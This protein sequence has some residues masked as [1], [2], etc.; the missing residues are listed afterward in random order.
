MIFNRLN[1]IEILIEVIMANGSLWFVFLLSYYLSS[2]I[3]KKVNRKRM[4]SLGTEYQN[5][6][7]EEKKNDYKPKSLRCSLLSIEQ[8][9][10]CNEFISVNIHMAANK[11]T[12]KSNDPFYIGKIDTKYR[13]NVINCLW[14][15]KRKKKIKKMIKN[16]NKNS[17]RCLFMDF[18][19]TVISS[20]CS[21]IRTFKRMF[22]NLL[23]GAFDL[24]CE[25]L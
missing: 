1:D 11:L 9:S 18:D 19:K 7:K 4:T 15:L 14:K 21:R 22:L 3:K 13:V 2:I 24:C 6:T 23:S 16:R 10:R 25:F 5:E 20:F 12:N 8:K 17:S